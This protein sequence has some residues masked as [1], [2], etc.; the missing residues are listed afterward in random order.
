MDWCTR[1]SYRRYVG[2]VKITRPYQGQFVDLY[3]AA[4]PVNKQNRVSTIPSNDKRNIYNPSPFDRTQ[5]N[6][7][8]DFILIPL[9][10]VS[11]RKANPW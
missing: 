5:F 4:T 8:N 7:I 9:S 3:A 1:G 11:F 6:P 10:S 2:M